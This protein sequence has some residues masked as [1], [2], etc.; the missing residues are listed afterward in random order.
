MY[1]E[2]FELLEAKIRETAMLV[3]RLRE[4]KRQLEQ[5]NEQLRARLAEVEVQ[6]RGTAAPAEDYGADLDHLL[7]QLDTLQQAEEAPQPLAVPARVPT[8]STPESRE[9]Y[10]QRGLLFEQQAQ[11][12]SALHAY[13]RALEMDGENLEAAQRLAFLLEKLNRDAE[14]A[15]LW[16]KIW[17]MREAQVPPRR[18]RL[19]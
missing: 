19:R 6:L 5:E 8:A 11:Y 16:D 17:A 10:V 18:R 12:E 1:A 9:D 4:E 13:Q 15:A 7:E 2:K 14:A 3:S